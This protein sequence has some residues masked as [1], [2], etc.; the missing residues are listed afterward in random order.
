MNPHHQNSSQ[1]NFSKLFGVPK[2]WAYL[3]GLN[4]AEC[5]CKSLPLESGLFECVKKIS[6]DHGLIVE[7]IFN[8][9]EQIPQT[10]PLLITANHPTGILDGVVVLCALL[11]RR[12]DVYVVANEILHKI[13]ILG[14]HII[15]VNKTNE[16]HKNNLSVLFKVRQAWQKN[17]CVVIF[18][19]GTVAHWQW[20]QHSITD[21]PW[22]TNLQDFAKKLNVPEFRASISLKNPIWF[23]ILAPLSKT[24]RIV[25][26]LHAFLNINKKPLS[27]PIG[28]EHVD[29]Q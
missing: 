6:Q 8:S 20:S 13:P 9:A 28:F 10:G 25:F 14:S 1:V 16:D 29:N 21:A 23:H 18:P 27:T 15:A 12:K 19:A 17:Q 22:N 2:I 5:Y 11:S 26:L 24:F 4:K 7:Q 3:L